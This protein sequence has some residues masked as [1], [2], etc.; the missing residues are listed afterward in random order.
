MNK[1]LWIFLILVFILI[2]ILEI[3]IP[4]YLI[5]HK[6]LGKASVYDYFW[7]EWR[8]FWLIFGFVGCLALILFSKLIVKYIIQREENYYE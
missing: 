8:G 2:L 4:N 1:A 3:Q 5:S 7:N 6:E